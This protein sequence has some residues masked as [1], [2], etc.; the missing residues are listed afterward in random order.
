MTDEAPKLAA[1]Q[2][3]THTEA[4]QQ[5]AHEAF[6]D[7]AQARTVD[8]PAELRE[9]R[10]IFGLIRLLARPCRHAAPDVTGERQPCPARVASALPACRR[11]ATSARTPSPTR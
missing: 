9:R 7:P 11:A 2:G 5:G 6:E 3:E 1:F 8:E 4:N 10:T